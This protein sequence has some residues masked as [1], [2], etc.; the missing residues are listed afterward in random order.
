MAGFFG[1]FDPTKPGKGVNPDKPGNRFST[2]WGIVWRK[3]TR[4]I[5]LNLIY[6]VIISP[7]L[8]F[9]YVILYSS[10]MGATGA[11][12]SEIS[13][14]VFQILVGIAQGMPQWMQYLLLAASVVFYGPAT[15]GMTYVLR[16]FAR[17]EHAWVSDFFTRMMMNFKQGLFFGLLDVLVFLAMSVNIPILLKQ[18][19]A[20]AAAG[21]MVQLVQGLAFFS[22]ALLIIYL[23]ARHYFFLLAVTFD[24]SILQILRNS[25]IFAV[26]G[27]GWNILAT[28]IMVA[29]AIFTFFVNPLIE[30]LMVFLIF[31]SFVMFIEIYLV[32]PK[33]KKIMIDPVL[34]KQAEQGEHHG[35]YP[36]V[37]KGQSL[38][39]PIDY[40]DRKDKPWLPPEGK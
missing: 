14:I 26:L 37:P 22:V 17:E 10:V 16:N 1:L 19:N 40:G 34:A 29:L 35:F 3:L 38:S 33:V 25:F 7:I 15:A 11:D 23:F 30:F 32:Y 28:V 21:D 13:T 27:L 31:F 18:E 4:L 12:I 24:S 6:F 8:T 9:L 36:P 5:L 20:L 39:D 2:F